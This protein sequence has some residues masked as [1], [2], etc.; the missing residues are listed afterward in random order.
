MDKQKDWLLKEFE[1]TTARVSKLETELQETTE[2]R[3]FLRK[4][5]RAV[6]AS[7]TSSFEIEE[8]PSKKVIAREAKEIASSIKEAV[9]KV[10]ELGRPVKAPDLAQAL[11]I[12][13]T[14]ARNRL[15]RATDLGLFERVGR[16]LYKIV[17]ITANGTAEIDK[18]SN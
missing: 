17:T 4:K 9:D 2:Y 16:G 1:S 6:L 15:Q 8:K 10:N 14:A 5:L 18:S 11:N 7:T 12:D 13:E 3:D